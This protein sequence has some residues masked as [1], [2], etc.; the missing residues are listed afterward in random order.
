MRFDLYYQGPLRA[1]GGRK[2][3]QTLRRAFHPQLRDLWQRAPLQDMADQF[4]DPAYELTVIRRVG[5][6][7]FAPLVSS[8]HHLLAELSITMLRP[9]EPGR[10]ITTGGDIDN[11]L[12]T[13]LDALSLP[14]HNQLPDG[15]APLNNEQ[16]M[17][18]LLEDDN[19]VTRLDVRVGRLLGEHHEADVL[20]LLSVEISATRATFKNS[21]FTG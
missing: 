21:V 14:K 5:D 1:S 17:H 2:E 6:F 9:E 18:C 7:D 20:L 12:K 19:L 11:R 16:P 8:T 15:D 3:K 13:L 4:L 10:L